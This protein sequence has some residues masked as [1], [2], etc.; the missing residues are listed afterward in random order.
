[1]QFMNMI[2]IKNMKYLVW[3]AVS[4]VKFKNKLFLIF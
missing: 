1:M 4:T 3:A 2:S